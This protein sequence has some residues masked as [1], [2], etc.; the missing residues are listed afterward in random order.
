VVTSKLVRYTVDTAT[1][2]AVP[3]SALELLHD[4]CGQFPS[5]AGG[6]MV[7]GDDGQLYL[8]GGD[9]ASFNVADYGQRGGTV[10][11]PANPITPINPCDDPVTVTSPPGTTPVVDVPSAEG[12]ALRSQ[13]LRTPGDPVTLDGSLIRINPATGA[14][15]AGNPLA[16]SSD[17]NARRIIAYG[18]RNAFRLTKDPDTGDLYVGDVG[19][20]RWE[21][22]NRVVPPSGPGGSVRNFGWPCYEGG[23][24]NNLPTSFKG[25]PWGTLGN[26]LCD[27]LYAAGPSAI[28]NPVYAYFHAGVNAACGVSGNSSASITGLAFYDAAAADGNVYPARHDGALFFVDYSRNCLVMLRRGA[29]GVPDLATAETVA[30][31]IGHPVDLVT[32]PH[33]DLY[34][35]DLDGSRIV[36]I[37][38][39]PSP[40]AHATASP[41]A[42]LAPVT[43]TLDASTSTDPDVDAGLVAWEWDLDDDGAFNGPAD[44]SG[45]VV[46]WQVTVPG[47]YPVT[48]RVTS[49]NGMTDTFDLS[50][51][52]NNQ[53]PVPH[54]AAPASSF[55]WSVGDAVSFS[56]SATDLEDGNLP[57]AALS[58]AVVLD[59]CSES[60]CHEHPLQ[61]FAGVA[62]GSFTAPDHPYPSHLELR[63]TA[64]DSD[65]ASVTTSIEL[66]PKTTTLDVT[67]V[68]AGV[69]IEVGSVTE[70]SPS[71]TTLIRGGAT[72]LVPPLVWV[73]GA[74][75]YRF[76]AWSDGLSRVHEVTVTNPASRTATYVPDAP[77]AC[78]AAKTVTPGAWVSERASGEGDVDWFRFTLPGRRRVV[79]T[80]GDLPV[81]AR[82]EL[83][84]G[85]SVLLGSADHAGTHFERLTRSLP[86]GT[87]R[88]R[89]R[90]PSGARSLSPYALRVLAIDDRVAIESVAVRRTGGS[91]RVAG[92]VVN[93][94]GAAVG[95]VTVTATFKDAQGRTVGTLRGTSFANR[96]ADGASS[97]F[98]LS[99]PVPAYVTVSYRRDPAAP[100]ASRSLSL[101]SLT[102]DPN[103]DGTI[104]DRGRV[105]NTGRVSATAVA[106]ARAWY[107]RR[108][109]VLDVRVAPVAPSTLGPGATGSFTIVRPSLASV[110][111]NATWLRGS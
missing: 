66:Q 62:S 2:V 67:S 80:L 72:T 27:G 28:V 83:Y 42:G 49:S 21:E 5:H 100:G 30:T 10:P 108:G 18:F 4:W 7:F 95:R 24:E 98:V 51:D 82:L 78:T 111:E 75:R 68:P 45:E 34:Y 19:N 59:H 94:T 79:V 11:D 99:G 63:L 6:A 39:A 86:A 69:P 76:G 9:G 47:V 52:A 64:T 90:V 33:G 13:D 102:H 74:N 29:G 56:G 25:V 71:E 70:P 35:A 77:D 8:A 1:N 91:V 23:V 50:F 44:K 32:G 109:E 105:R 92:Q 20:V 97:P 55:T 41:S 93:G 58:W 22:I 57:A 26:N 87:Y 96:L 60:D 3:G 106:A 17:A 103:P 31:G 88:V 101:V 85:C 104:T 84:G 36:R 40:V 89:V 43:V 37:R 46:Q 61:T 15:S 14:A 110:Q 73:S 16:G 53:P 12:G 81:N 38:Y 107:G 65:G 54:I 48:L